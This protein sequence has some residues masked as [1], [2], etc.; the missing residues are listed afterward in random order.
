MTLNENVKEETI[1]TLKFSLSA[2]SKMYNTTEEQIL[3]EYIDANLDSPILDC[4]NILTT[5][6]NNK[7]KETLDILAKT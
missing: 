2:L 5:N 3:K 7:L 1:K 4:V 6:Q